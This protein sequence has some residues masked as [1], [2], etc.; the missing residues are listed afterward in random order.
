MTHLRGLCLSN[1][2]NVDALP[3]TM[4]TGIPGIVG[5]CAVLI[6]EGETAPGAIGEPN[7]VLL[8]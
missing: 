4:R 7:V 6:L 2:I 1:P 8:F 5:D 3:A